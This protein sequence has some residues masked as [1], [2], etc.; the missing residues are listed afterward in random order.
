MMRTRAMRDP[1]FLVASLV[2]TSGAAGLYF[3]IESAN[4]YLTKLPIHARNG[5]KVMSLP[6]ETANWIRVGTDQIE[7]AEIIDELDT[8][9]YLTRT[10]EEK[11][12]KDGKPP[13]RVQLHIAYYTGMIDTVPHVPDRC[14]IGG[15]FREGG[16][17]MSVPITLDDSTWLPTEDVRESWEGQVFT[18]KASN[19]YGETGGARIT[20]PRNPHDISMRAMD[21]IDDRSG[22]TLYAGYFFIAN[23]GTVE[24][25]EGV[26]ML[27]FDLSDDYAY[28]LKV[29]VT[30]Q[31][32]DSLDELGEV[33]SSLINDL[34]GDIM[35]CLPDWVEVDQGLWPL[36]NPRRDKGGDSIVPETD[37]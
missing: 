22:R 18:M 33:A 29:Q 27:A 25:A 28:Y 26:R 24:R 31:M 32:V 19:E 7:S 11:H 15:G 21:F 10:Y 30:S 14:F 20:L 4:V 13:R 9:E 1:A 37:G 16:H 23:G 35:Y 36:N 17:I 2:L 8:D 12:G 6:I 3:A 5:L 34:I